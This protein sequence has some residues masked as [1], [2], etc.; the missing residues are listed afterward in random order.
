[1]E[2][3]G[4]HYQLSDLA[5][6]VLG[7]KL[8]HLKRAGFVFGPPN[9]A[10]DI[11]V[12]PPDTDESEGLPQPEERAPR[13]TE[14]EVLPEILEFMD[15]SGGHAALKDIHKKFKL[16]EK[17]KKRLEAIGFTFADNET[18]GGCE[19][20]MPEEAAAGVKRKAWI[21]EAR[22]NAKRAATTPA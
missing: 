14:L 2:E 9:E 11:F 22:A 19:V 12:Y 6:S 18:F 5:S 1:L 3:K 16:K 13:K 4:G 21:G 17:P 10:G 7:T 15:E 8:S 20:F